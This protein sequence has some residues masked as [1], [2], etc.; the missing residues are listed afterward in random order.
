MNGQP[1]SELV[2]NNSWKEQKKLRQVLSNKSFRLQNLT[3]LEKGIFSLWHVAKAN[4][5]LVYGIS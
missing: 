2:E 1:G 3:E 5:K 4:R